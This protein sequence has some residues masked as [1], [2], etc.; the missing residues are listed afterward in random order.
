MVEQWRLPPRGTPVHALGRFVEQEQGGLA[1]D[2]A[3]HDDLL[4][5]ATGQ[6]G[7]RCSTDEDLTLNRALRLAL[8]VASRGRG[9]GHPS[10]S[11][12]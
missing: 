1:T 2:Q 4:L 5:V 12:Q 8:S 11:G 3:R 10:N 9:C 6:R 7:E